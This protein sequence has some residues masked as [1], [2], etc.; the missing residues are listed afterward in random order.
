MA[1][2]KRLIKEYNDIIRCKECI[3]NRISIGLLEENNY[4]NWCATI[5][6]SDDTPYAGGIFKLVINIPHSYPFKPPKV[7]FET[8]IFHPNINNAGEICIDI[9]KHN[10]SPALTLDKLLLSIALLM[11]HPNPDDPLDSTAAS[12]LKNNPEEYKKKVREM[13]L[14]Y[15]NGSGDKTK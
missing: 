11:A 13:V 12:L 15:A 6:G 14:K 4:S 7:K 2:T 10:W 8:P 9:L 3:D 5:M 1:A